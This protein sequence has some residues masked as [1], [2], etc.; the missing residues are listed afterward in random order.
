MLSSTLVAHVFAIVCQSDN[1]RSFVLC[2]FVYQRPLIRAVTLPLCVFC[3]GVHLNCTHFLCTE[4]CS[5]FL[6]FLLETVYSLTRTSLLFLF[7][8]LFEVLLSLCLNCS[9][10]CFDALYDPSLVPHQWLPNF[11]WLT[12]VGMGC[13]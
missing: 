10:L 4:E 1:V 3:S 12:F 11:A 13:S 7:T 6:K 9:L 2:M 8:Q 5:C